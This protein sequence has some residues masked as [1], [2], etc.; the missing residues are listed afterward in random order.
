MHSGVPRI[1]GAGRGLVS[2]AVMRAF[3]VGCLVAGLLDAAD[4][5]KAY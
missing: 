2:A 5:I 3:L 4:R 1:V